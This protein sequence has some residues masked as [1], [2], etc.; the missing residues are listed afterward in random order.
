MNDLPSKIW[1]RDFIQLVSLDRYEAPV[2]YVDEAFPS[3]EAIEGEDIAIRT[4]DPFELS[5]IKKLR[6]GQQLLSKE[7]DDQMMVVGA[8]RATESC[9][10]C[11]HSKD[12]ELLGAFAY[13]FRR[14]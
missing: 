7:T 12:G 3:M 8:L 9:H 10:Q 2:A 1:R 5:A 6:A 13:R 4:L 14:D 11:H